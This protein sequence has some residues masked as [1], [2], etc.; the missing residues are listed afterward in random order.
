MKEIIG[1]IFGTLIQPDS[2]FWDLFKGKERLAKEF[3]N[4]VLQKVHESNSAQTDI[5]KIEAKHANIFV[6]GWRPS[7]GWVISFAIFYNYV[8]ISF[9]NYLILIF[10]KNF[11]IPPHLEIAEILPILLALLGLAGYRT[12]EKKNKID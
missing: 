4:E 5:N 9:L 10:N 3:Q 8:I 11:P 2:K 12:Y 6:S 7:V 1:G